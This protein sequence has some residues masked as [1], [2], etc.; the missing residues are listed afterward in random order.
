MSDSGSDGSWGTQWVAL[1]VDS[2]GKSMDAKKLP[3]ALAV[4]MNGT[5]AVPNV[6][7]SVGSRE[8]QWGSCSAE[9]MSTS[10]GIACRRAML[11]V[12]WAVV[13]MDT[14]A[15]KMVSRSRR[16]SMPLTAKVRG[17]AQ[18][19]AWKR[20][21]ACVVRMVSATPHRSDDGLGTKTAVDSV[22][23]MGH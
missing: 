23:T 15:V 3:E 8:T 2:K 7:R 17:E 9:L 21:V 1:L 20:E 22:A 16:R 4:Q 12:Q 6:E 14:S 10:M 5:T 19:G 18:M 11:E 13:E